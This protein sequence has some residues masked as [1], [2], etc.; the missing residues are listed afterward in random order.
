MP[1]GVGPIFGL[2]YRSILVWVPS[3]AGYR[4]P[5]GGFEFGV[6]RWCSSVSDERG[7]YHM[8]GEVVELKESRDLKNAAEGAFQRLARAN[9]WKVTKRGW[10]DCLCWKDDGSLFAVE[11]KPT[12]RYPLR[13]EQEFVLQLLA[14]YGIRSYRWSPKDGF[15]QIRT[16]SER[17]RAARERKRQ[18]LAGGGG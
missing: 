18:K 4:V 7:R 3:G 1:S 13:P 11:I 10:P 9:G 12:G 8:T 16:T 5:C 2:G 17:Y 6:G 14:D 15:K